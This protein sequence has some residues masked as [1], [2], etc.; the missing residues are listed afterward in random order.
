MSARKVYKRSIIDLSSLGSCV[1]C[2]HPADL[3]AGLCRSCHATLQPAP[4]LACRC[5]LPLPGATHLEDDT[6]TLPLCGSCLARPPA[7][8]RVCCAHSYAFP[9]D[10]LFNRYKHRRQLSAE[11]ALE[12]LWLAALPFPGPLPDALVPMP[13]HWR[14]QWW[15]GFNPATRLAHAASRRLGVPLLAALHRNR[16]TPRQ[17]YLGA[18]RRERNLRGALTV[19]RPVAGLS[20]ALVDDVVTTGSSAREA[21]ARLVAAGAAQ[22]QVWALARTLP[23]R[24]E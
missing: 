13:S 14:R 23:G 1:L 11:R 21:S 7:F 12:H 10:Q 17:Q 8:A 24:H 9:L 16:A 5:G 4:A 22:V 20:L 15:R 6:Q 19:I 2:R 18:A 3:H